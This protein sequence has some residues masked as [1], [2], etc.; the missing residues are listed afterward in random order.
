MGAEVFAAPEC[1][2]HVWTGSHTASGNA[3][4][5]AENVNITLQTDYDTLPSL[6]GTYRDHL[7][8]RRANINIGAA[9]SLSAVLPRWAASA[10]AV[11]MKATFNQVGAGSAG[12][13][14][15][16]GRLDNVAIAGAIN[17][18]FT[19][20]VQAHANIWTGF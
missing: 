14:F 12:F 9:Y 6:S 1:S 4:T 17:G 16:S 10:T 5:Y 2:L 7:T 15:Y 18:V 13:I 20:Q 8:N 11:H 3:V 19:F